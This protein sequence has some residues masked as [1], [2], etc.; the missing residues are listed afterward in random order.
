[1]YQL[2]IHIN[3][4]I[5]HINA[6][7][8]HTILDALRAN[9][10]PINAPCAGRGTCGK[11]K[12]LC[13]GQLLMSANMHSQYFYGEVNACRCKPAGTCEIWIYDEKFSFSHSDLP[14]LCGGGEGKG[15]FV[16]IGTTT[17]SSGIYD[18]KSGKCIRKIS[19]LNAQRLYGADVISR[20]EYCRNGE[21]DHLFDCTKT[22]INE[23]IDYKDLNR[24]SIVGN[25]IM[26]H[27][28]AQIDPSSI[29]IPPFIPQH[30][31][32]EEIKSLYQN[33]DTYFAPCI[34]GYV[35]G[36]IIA[37]L[38]ACN[39]HIASGLQL[40]VDIGTNGEIA[41]GNSH[42]YIT[43]ATSA[44]PAFEGAE[45]E[46][47]MNAID[48]A[49][50]HIQSNNGDIYCHVIG[51]K[52][53]KGICGS[54]IIDAVAVMLDLHLINKTGR[55]VGKEQVPKNLQWRFSFKNGYKVFY[56]CD[57][58]YLT[59]HDIHNVQLA[60]AA[61]MAGIETLVKN[62]DYD[63]L[64]LAGGFG[65]YIDISNAIRI[66]LLPKIQENKIRQAGN[67]AARGAALLLEDQSRAEIRLLAK[68]CS[69]IDLSLSNSFSESFIRNINFR[70]SKSDV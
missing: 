1:M 14:I 18:L 62:R 33:I 2:C 7:S 53:A 10:I 60:K 4:S 58:V 29:S 64:T 11:C 56:L 8:E 59:Q 35:G 40:Y 61:I 48:G 22:Q 42:G 41:F 68:S 67:A 37:G 20:L 43:C 5:F 51:N 31:F 6:D 39:L 47:G 25:T 50:D 21:L 45:I 13:K 16:D 63:C 15:L 19:M 34:S 23:L 49:I 52:V 32:G 69:Y 28:A 12:L 70:N 38:L 30:F 36:D 46:C 55:F 17:I 24:I 26:E 3:N 65:N 44:G 9:G 54:G 27:L 66:G 57:K